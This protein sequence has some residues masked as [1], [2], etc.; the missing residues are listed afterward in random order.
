MLLSFNYLVDEWSIAMMSV[1]VTV[2]NFNVS[3][4]YFNLAM[5]YMS[6]SLS[7]SCLWNVFF[8]NSNRVAMSSSNFLSKMIF[9]K[10]ILFRLYL[11]SLSVDSK[12]SILR[13]VTQKF[14]GIMEFL[15][16][17][18]LVKKGSTCYCFWF[19]DT[20][21]DILFS[22]SFA[23]MDGNLF[24]IVNTNHLIIDRLFFS[25]Y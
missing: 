6:I 24:V 3:E 2:L 5:F 10:K 13:T 14:L 12:D 7:V 18:N 22:Y 8:R 17:K 11:L 20:H 1:S 23:L 16:S 4:S 15:S 25:L 9:K 19:P 21:F